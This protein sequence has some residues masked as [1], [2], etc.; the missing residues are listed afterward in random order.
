MAWLLHTILTDETTGMPTVFVKVVLLRSQGM[1]AEPEREWDQQT[2]S[3]VLPGKMAIS[4]SLWDLLGWAGSEGGD[5]HR[6]W[7]ASPGG[8]SQP[9][10][11]GF[12]WRWVSGG[13]VKGKTYLAIKF[14]L[15]EKGIRFIISLWAKGRSWFFRFQLPRRVQ[16]CQFI[17][18]EKQKSLWSFKLYSQHTFNC[19][20]IL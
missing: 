16:I 19:R 20:E 1:Q 13:A 6:Q 4:S 3:E 15:P 8:R 12:S 5:K 7:C 10:A 2:R 14:N 18:L 11:G 17:I 9:W